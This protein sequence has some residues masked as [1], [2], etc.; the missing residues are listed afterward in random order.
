MAKRLNTLNIVIAV[1]Q[2][3][4]EWSG[5]QWH[6]G[7]ITNAARINLK[8][9]KKIPDQPRYES[10]IAEASVN[11]YKNFIDPNFISE[12]G[13]TK[14]EIVAKHAR[15]ISAGFEK[16]NKNLDRAFAEDGKIFKQ[17]IADS[18]ERYVKNAQIT[19]RLTGDK[20]RGYGASALVPFWLVANRRIVQLLEHA[21]KIEGA[22]VNII[23]PLELRGAFKAGLEPLLTQTGH[24]IIRAEFDRD[25]I[26]DQNKLVNKFIAGLQD[27]KYAK[28]TPGGDSHCDWGV[29]ESGEFYIEVQLSVATP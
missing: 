8:R 23:Q 25:T 14:K 19:M 3:L 27:N 5:G 15:K 9:K 4:P 18:V 10:K 28:F 21:A 2:S 29:E 16:Y 7:M 6:D 24:T 20:I 17:R 1:E 22:P 12:A 26:N 13:L 11:V